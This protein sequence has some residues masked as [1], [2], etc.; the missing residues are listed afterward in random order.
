VVSLRSTVL[1]RGAVV[2]NA[3]RVDLA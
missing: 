1:E 2:L 3:G